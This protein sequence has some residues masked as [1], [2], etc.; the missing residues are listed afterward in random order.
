[1][2]FDVYGVNEDVEKAA[3]GVDNVQTGVDKTEF[4][5]LVPFW[6]KDEYAKKVAMRV[7]CEV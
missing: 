7:T 6:V 5:F 3:E 2:K 4:P 1:M